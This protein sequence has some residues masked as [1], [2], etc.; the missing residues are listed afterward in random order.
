VSRCLVVFRDGKG[1]LAVVNANIYVQNR[2]EHCIFVVIISIRFTRESLRYTVCPP[3]HTPLQ[4]LEHTACTYIQDD[5]PL[6]VYCR[7]YA[8]STRFTRFPD[9]SAVSYYRDMHS[10]HYNIIKSEKKCII[11]LRASL[12]QFIKL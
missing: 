5:A 7:Y 2:R 10:L 1:Q 12:F 8:D 4:L 11:M 6:Q 3:L 9:R